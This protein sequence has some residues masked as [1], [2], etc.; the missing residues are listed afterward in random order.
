VAKDASAGNTITTGSADWSRLS[1]RAA[2][3]V[4]HIE[5]PVFAGWSYADIAAAHGITKKHITA[6]RAELREELEHLDPEQPCLR[7]LVPIPVL[8]DALGMPAVEEELDG[9]AEVV[10]YDTVE[11]HVRHLELR[12]RRERS[13]ATTKRL[14]D[15]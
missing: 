6:L 14:D 1:D 10:V 11:A 12:R 9:L 5:M 3:T 15:V 4:A 8:H 7:R 13:S 2:W